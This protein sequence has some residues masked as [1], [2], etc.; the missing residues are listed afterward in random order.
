MQTPKRFSQNASAFVFPAENQKD[1]SLSVCRIFYK[2]VYEDFAGRQSVFFIYRKGGKSFRPFR[3]VFL[4]SGVTEARL[5]NFT[6]MRKL[7]LTFVLA[8]V[9]S[10][11]F[12]QLRWDVKLGLNFSNMTQWDVK[13]LPGFTLGAGMDYEFNES[14]AFQPGLMFTSRG[15][16]NGGW[17]VRPVYM[18]I[19]ILA[20]YKI[21]LTENARFVINAGPYVAIGLGGKNKHDGYESKVFDSWKRGDFGFQ[22]GVGFELSDHYLVNFAAQHG[23]I[24]PLELDGPTDHPKNMNFSIGVGYR[25]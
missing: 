6:A 22:W 7:L 10:V 12:S 14:W 21:T 23:F 15:Y 24:S 20:A 3:Q 2:F 8:M 1:F 16:K 18:D 5:V 25:F 9:A 17:K 4:E 13:A 19:P 11:G